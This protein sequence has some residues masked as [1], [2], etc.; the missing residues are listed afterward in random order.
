MEEGGDTRQV[1]YVSFVCC[2]Y[3]IPLSISELISYF[4]W[5]LTW[6]VQSYSV[7]LK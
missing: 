7:N 1:Q 4:K 5:A 3:D 2:Y 6:V